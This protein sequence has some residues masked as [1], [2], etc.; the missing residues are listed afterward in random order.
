MAFGPVLSWQGDLFG[1]TV[2]LA[3]RLVGAAHPGTILVSDAAAAQLQN[4][5]LT[6]KPIRGVKMKGIE[7]EKV[8][9]LRRAYGG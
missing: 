7:R 5:G 9:V 1:T 6:L 8:F 2:N 4:D 3:S